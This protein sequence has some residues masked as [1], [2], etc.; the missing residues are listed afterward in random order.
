M[1]TFFPIP[2]IKR[3]AREF[4]GLRDE[5]EVKKKKKKDRILELKKKRKNSSL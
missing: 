1:K 2:G 5:Q 3:S 4:V